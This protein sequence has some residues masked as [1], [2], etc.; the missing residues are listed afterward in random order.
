[1]NK[2]NKDKEKLHNY[3]TTVTAIVSSLVAIASI[4]LSIYS[5][6]LTQKTIFTLEFSSL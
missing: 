5:Y 3:I 2:Q 4:I 6:H 1:M